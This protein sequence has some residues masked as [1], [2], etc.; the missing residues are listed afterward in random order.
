MDNDR[1]DIYDDY[2]AEITHSRKKNNKKNVKVS[3]NSSKKSK[4]KSKKK[5]RSAVAVFV[6]T[7]IVTLLVLSVIFGAWFAYRYF[8]NATGNVSE[9]EKLDPISQII[10]EAA[11]N[12]VEDSYQSLPDRT[13]FLIVGTDE[14]GTRTDTI[15]LC[16]YNKNIHALDMIS[17]PRDTLVE[18]DDETFAK[19]NEEYPEPGQKG[20]KINALHHYG[21]DK[22]G[23]SFLEAQLEKMFDCKI[24]F[25]VKVSF[26]AFDYLVDSIGGVEYNVPIPMHYEDPTQNLA[27]HL[28]PGLQTLNGEQA[29]WLVRFRSGYSNADLGRIET[30]QNFIK[31]LM[32]KLL[33]SETVLSNTKSYLTAAFKYVESDAKI[34]DLLKYMTL[35]KE[36]TSDNLTT[37]TLPGDVGDGFGFRG[38]YVYYPE[39]TTQLGYDIFKKPDDQILKDKQEIAEAES[40]EGQFD[41]TKLVIQVLN[42]GYT[43]GMASKFQQILNTQGFNIASIDTWTGNKAQKTRIYV[44]EDGMGQDIKDYFSDAEIITDPEMAKDYDIV[45]IIGMGEFIATN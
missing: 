36:F 19:M 21:G 17:I 27:I 41:D 2:N 15:M 29:E 45:I 13:T 25:Y 8:K 24:D 39:D 31:I 14:D 1:Y 44:K 42:G 6:I 34:A 22:Y 18:V 33:N 7:F 32:K 35:L 43:D 11:K 28:N 30:Q 16:C 40:K 12:T 26:E 10:D 38:A 4:P 37:Y 3:E 20:M 9:D 5:G 23:M